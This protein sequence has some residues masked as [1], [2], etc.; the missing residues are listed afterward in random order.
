[1]AKAKKSKKVQTK[2]PVKRAVKKTSASKKAT[3]KSA[4]K[5]A[6]KKS[7]VV[8]VDLSPPVPKSNKVGSWSFLLGFIFAVFAGFVSI[9]PSAD[10]KF[11][12]FALIVFGILIGFLNVRDHQAKDFML[13]GTVLVLVT[14]LGLATVSK[15]EFYKNIL[16]ALETL[17]VPATIIV[18]LRV[19]FVLGHKK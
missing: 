10:L 5:K 4:P 17:F 14:Y 16:F 8:H 1:M 15:V 2:K 6:V 3:N 18:A 11:I 19:L 12:N 9:F 7:T 13:A